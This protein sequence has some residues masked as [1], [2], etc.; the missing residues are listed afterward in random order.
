MDPLDEGR[1]RIPPQVEQRESPLAELVDRVTGKLVTA[2]VLASGIVGLAIYSR[3]SPPRY[4]AVVAPDG[5]I[6]RV[7]TRNGAIVVCRDERCSILLSS[8]QHLGRNRDKAEPAQVPAP[9]QP[10][11]VVPPQPAPQPA[12][13]PP[14]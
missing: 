2:L 11:A 10:P 14:R 9:A 5:R 7:N 3:P 13:Q 8:S 4:Q 12:Q 6:V 1:G